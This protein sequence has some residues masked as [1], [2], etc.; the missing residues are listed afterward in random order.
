MRC[1]CFGRGVFIAAGG[2]PG[3]LQ[4]L[5]STSHSYPDHVALERTVPITYR[6]AHRGS[7]HITHRLADLVTIFVANARTNSSTDCCTLAAS[8]AVPDNHADG[9][10]NICTFS[11]SNRIPDGL[12]DFHSTDR[13]SNACMPQLRAGSCR[14][15]NDHRGSWVC[16]APRSVSGA[17]QR[18]HSSADDVAERVAIDEYPNAIANEIALCG[19]YKKSN[20]ITFA[21]PIR[22]SHPTA[23][24]HPNGFP[25]SNAVAQS[26][27]I[28]NCITKRVTNDITHHGSHFRANHEP[29]KVANNVSN[30]RAISVSDAT[31]VNISIDDADNSIPD[32]HSHCFTNIL[33]ADLITY[34]GTDATVCTIRT[35]PCFMPCGCAH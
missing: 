15:P 29:H 23:N 20:R 27:V 11:E 6:L 18:V 32:S 24:S 14:L 1:G 22:V 2:V 17:L 13:I 9:L 35:R 25:L 5:H 30:F 33:C 31:P 7:H 16:L 3:A 28:P 26:I 4:C 21:Q 12:T 34:I 10:A 8:N 19:S